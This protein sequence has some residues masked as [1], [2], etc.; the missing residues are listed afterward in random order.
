MSDTPRTD[1]LDYNQEI[2]SYRI[3]DLARELERE[4]ARLR[5]ELA[6]SKAEIENIKKLLKDPTAVHINMLRDNI[7]ILSWDSY[8]HIIGPH[9]CRNEVARLREELNDSNS[10]M[11]E[12]KQKQASLIA[13]VNY[14]IKEFPSNNASIYLAGIMEKLFQK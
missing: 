11:V 6:E 8:E 13:A 12:L 1:E 10:R 4:V 9:P 5:E 2:K 7:A 14:A 3:W